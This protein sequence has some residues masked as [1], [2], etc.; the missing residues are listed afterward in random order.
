[1]WA[2]LAKRLLLFI[3]T[4]ILVTT[5]VFV[6]MRLVPGDPAVILLAG[7][8]GDQP[9][10]QQELKILRAKLGTDKP[11]PVEYGNWIWGL[12]RGDFG[13]SMQYNTPIGDD[14]SSKI[15]ITL[16]LAIL[17]LLLAVVA[18]VPLGVFSAVYQDTL[19][20]YIARI[21]AIDGVAIPTFWVGILV[22]YLLVLLFN[23]L[24]PFGYAQLWEDPGRNLQQMIFPALA[25]GFYNM[26]LIARVT[27][28]SMLEV[29]R[30]DYIRTQPSRVPGS[31]VRGR[32][33][34]ERETTA[35]SLAGKE[36]SS[37]KED[38]SGQGKDGPAGAIAQG[39]N[40]R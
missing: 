29:L 25:L 3:P 10:S 15:P 6:L 23:W 9:V 40:G 14:L 11:I 13:T 39:G 7:E 16:E 34:G 12:L 22:I 21:I 36:E 17:A 37:R 24:P 33:S 26:A 1:M 31:G 19:G 5:L 4:L 35:S 18:A 32:G 20:D 27:R 8:G 30:E 38:N 28:S 2:Y